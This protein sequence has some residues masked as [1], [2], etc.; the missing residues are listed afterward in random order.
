MAQQTSYSRDQSTAITPGTPGDA[1]FVRVESWTNGQ[2]TDLPAGLLVSKKASTE[3]SFDLGTTSTDP[4]AGVIIHSHSRGI[5]HSGDELAAGC[6]V[7]AAAS[8]ELMA[9]GAI[10]VT[11]EQAMTPDD[12]V[13]VRYASGAGGTQLGSVR[14]DADT[15]TARRCK[16][17]RVIKGAGA[18]EAGIIYFSAAAEAA[19]F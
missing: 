16:G 9:E 2:G 5:G 17:A 19:S 13:F 6:S 14:K 1:G 4:V 12:L 8:C 11:F 10:Y 15:A 7:A 18:G 3:G